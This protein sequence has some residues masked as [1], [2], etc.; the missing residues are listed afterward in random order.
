MGSADT[1]TN[2]WRPLAKGAKVSAGR[3]TSICQGAAGPD[4]GLMK[5]TWACYRGS[6]GQD[7]IW[8]RV[9]FGCVGSKGKSSPNDNT[10][11]STPETSRL[12][13]VCGRNRRPGWKKK[14]KINEQYDD[15]TPNMAAVKSK[16]QKAKAFQAMTRRD[17]NGGKLFLAAFVESQ[18]RLEST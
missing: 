13:D 5:A 9:T 2:R 6:V 14:K 3:R 10:D 4:D 11:Q 1:H 16:C 18:R 8:L 7:V 17:R 15:G 12:W